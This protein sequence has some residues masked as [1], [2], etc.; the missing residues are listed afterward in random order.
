MTDPM[1]VGLLFELDDQSSSSTKDITSNWGKFEKT[2]DK[3]DDTFNKFI[4]KMGKKTESTSEKIEEALT[5]PA[6]G[7][8]PKGPLTFWNNFDDVLDDIDNKLGTRLGSIAGN[9]AQVGA[10]WLI[11][12][13]SA[14]AGMRMV[15][16]LN[17]IRLSAYL[18]REEMEGMRSVSTKT[19][20]R[21]GSDFEDTSRIMTLAV[22]NQIKSREE[23]EA[24]TSA[25]YKMSKVTDISEDSAER[26]AVQMLNIH[27]IK[28]SRLEAIASGMVA[29]RD[30]TKASSA[31]IANLLEQSETF[32]ERIP[33]SMKEGGI[34]SLIAVAGAYEDTGGVA[35]E[36]GDILTRLTD[37]TDES[38]VGLRNL[39]AQ[40]G[41]GIDQIQD[42]LKRGDI[43]KLYSA[44]A[45][46]AAKIADSPLAD[47]PGYIQQYTSL[48]ERTV[49]LL[50]RTDTSKLK[51]LVD[52]TNKEVKA[53]TLLTDRFEDF[54]SS[55]WEGMWNR[56]KN[57]TQGLVGGSMSEAGE[58]FL[59][60]ASRG[61]KVFSTIG[62]WFADDPVGKHIAKWGSLL[63]SGV[64]GL[65]L[66]KGG[67]ALAGKLLTPVAAGMG[68]IGLG[69]LPKIIG[70]F[71]KLFTG[72][73]GWTLLGA[74]LLIEKTIGW[75]KALK[76]VGLAW[77][78]ISNKASDAD[79]WLESNYQ[80]YSKIK[81]TLKDTVD[82]WEDF[83]KKLNAY[84]EAENRAENL[85]RAV[86][87]K[88]E[89]GNYERRY[90]LSRPLTPK[91][92]D[93]ALRD[94]AQYGMIGAKP[95]RHNLENIPSAERPNYMEL[96]NR[97][98]PIPPTA[99]TDNSS[100]DVVNAIRHLEEV[101][102]GAFGS[103]KLAPSY[104]PSRRDPLEDF[105]R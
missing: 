32:I 53:A 11:V 23:V 25:V 33:Q 75:D 51:Q 50:A 81:G 24:F 65:K 20:V 69:F 12:A 99:I 4:D 41:I 73:I 36:I 18:T 45:K 67:L 48:S 42:A 16:V 46:G 27:N 26:L 10:Q 31:E 80:W 57:S 6:Q 96:L 97:R 40:G 101:L 63:I 91:E 39:A 105:N 5:P 70:G 2:I 29:V 62:E 47:L 88:W 56:I 60:T 102:R 38:A 14:R 9:I 52:L 79:K 13:G 55:T 92:Q 98:N 83:F 89:A 93:K 61:L 90:N 86:E 17:Q 8:G 103:L 64:V 1:K 34:A 76:F 84:L 71:T 28:P 19:M 7:R 54:Q 85:K 15:G 94:L 59:R 100:P 35:S 58:W 104:S 22:K 95:D 82:I 21:L 77:D 49:R 3:L 66:F 78:V 68:K 87:K 72:P 30:R 44:I 43:D 37:I 74:D